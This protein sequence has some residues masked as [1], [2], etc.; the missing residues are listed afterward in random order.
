MA[1]LVK[2]NSIQENDLNNGVSIDSNLK[3]SGTEIASKTSGIVN[4]QNTTI[5]NNVVFPAGHVIQT[6]T[7]E[8]DTEYLTTS[9]ST[10]TQLTN[11]RINITPTIANSKLLIALN[12]VAKMGVTSGN[13]RMDAKITIGGSD[14]ERFYGL[15]FLN[16]NAI[17]DEAGWVHINKLY[18]HGQTS[19]FTELQID[20]HIIRGSNIGAYSETAF[21]WDANGANYALSYVMEIAP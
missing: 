7:N 12:G 13:M 9:T 5:N 1:S 11:L 18:L 10:W 2:V 8:T 4:L 21:N 6:Q 3:I 14:L 17:D 15:I 19:S 20:F 16:T